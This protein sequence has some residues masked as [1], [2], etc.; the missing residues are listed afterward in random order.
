MGQLVD[1]LGLGLGMMGG[2]SSTC[3][4][5]VLITAT[6]KPETSS[7]KIKSSQWFLFIMYIRRL[8]KKKR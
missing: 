5:R 6:Y 1:R 4:A 2:L 7:V 3:F 8:E